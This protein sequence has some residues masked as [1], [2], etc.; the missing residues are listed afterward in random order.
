MT[1]LL[2]TLLIVTVF[3][4][5]A[6]A[7]DPY[8]VYV[9]IS[10][11]G[12]GAFV[13]AGQVNAFKAAEPVINRT[14]GIHGRPVHF[15]VQDD[16]TNPA[17]AVQIFNEVVAKHVPII[18]GPGFSAPCYAVWPL[19]K[20]QIV[21]YCLAP[22]IHPD[23]GS[24]AFS[25]SASTKDLA[26]AGIRFFHAHGWKKVA[27]LDTTDATGQG[28]D[29]TSSRELGAAKGF[30]GH[31]NRRLRALRSVRRYDQRA[32]GAHQGLGRASDHLVG[33]RH[34]IRD[35]VPRDHRRGDRASDLY[36][37]RQ[38]QL[39]ADGSVQSVPAEEL[40]LLHGLSLHGAQQLRSSG[41]PQSTV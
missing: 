5:R 27:V 22:S 41:D 14:G 33:D 23:P 7:A 29:N 30:Q 10:L 11:T 32:A 40:T 19:V 36:Q 31:G 37:R 38:H 21:N 2:A 26:L 12:Q 18:L 39:L 35:R 8:D 6:N 13:G 28:N 9:E 4:A 1:L 3:G 34:P 15:V 20:D 24:Y 25:A 17:Q 16:G